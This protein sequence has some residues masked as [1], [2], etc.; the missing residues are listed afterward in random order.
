M[1]IICGGS[2]KKKSLI[3]M[4][5]ICIVLS[6][7]TNYV[8][9]ESVMLEIKCNKNDL[10]VGDELVINYVLTNLSTKEM[11]FSELNID[12]FSMVKSFKDKNHNILPMGLDEELEVRL[13]P[14]LED[15][16]VL[17]P[18]ESKS[19]TFSYILKNGTINN[20]IF[21]NSEEYRGYY[22]N[23]GNF[24]VILGNASKLYLQVVYKLDRAEIY[25][26]E[27]RYFIKDLYKG[28]IK[29]NIEIIRIKM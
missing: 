5:L 21:Y 7:S 11:V 10:R 4:F 13:Y 28:Q 23:D 26:G 9:G 27:K 29:S 6:V 15:F 25:W 20:L 22:L 24:Y 3:F 2:M 16:F 19:F 12:D 1:I 17:K 18:N 14:L 8:L